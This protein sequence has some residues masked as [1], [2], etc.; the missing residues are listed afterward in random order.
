MYCSSEEVD[1]GPISA[2][3][4]RR[5]R[6]VSS[7]PPFHSK[8]AHRHKAYVLFWWGMVDSDHRS[9]WQQIYSLPPLAAREIPHMELVIG[10]EPTTCWLQI[11][12]SAIEPHQHLLADSC[13][14][15]DIISQTFCFVN[16]FFKKKIKK[17]FD[18]IYLPLTRVFHPHNSAICLKKYRRAFTPIC[19]FIVYWFIFRTK[20]HSRQH[21]QYVA[22][23]QSGRWLSL[24]RVRSR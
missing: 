8:K 1:S 11:S 12:C 18:T 22:S 24:H 21:P 6:I 20:S 5:Q 19:I 15:Y 14:D 23:S 10:V 17:F 9:Q 7:V 4:R 2:P 13:A 16:T 3:P